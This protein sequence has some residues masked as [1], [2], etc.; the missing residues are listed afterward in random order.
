MEK[1]SVIR[2]KLILLFIFSIITFQ[3]KGQDYFEMKCIGCSVYNVLDSTKVVNEHLGKIIRISNDV[4][5]HYHENKQKRITIGN[6]NY[7]RLSQTY[8]KWCGIDYWIV[9]NRATFS[10]DYSCL[11]ITACRPV[12]STAVGAKRKMIILYYVADLTAEPISNLDS[13]R[14]FIVTCPKCKGTGK[15]ESQHPD[16][17]VGICELCGGKKKIVKQFKI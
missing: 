15:I 8:F 11:E 5:S 9:Y 12:Y 3:I 13:E 7:Q 2:V 17:S 14:N 1:I 4:K 16:E 10:E 6:R